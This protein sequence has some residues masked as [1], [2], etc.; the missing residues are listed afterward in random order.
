[1]CILFPSNKFEIRKTR[2]PFQKCFMQFSNTFLND[3][4]RYLQYILYDVTSNKNKINSHIIYIHKGSI[5]N[6]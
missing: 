6:Q 4:I 2:R 1:M 5:K 3:Y